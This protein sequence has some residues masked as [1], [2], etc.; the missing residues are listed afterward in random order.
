MADNCI[1]C[2]IVK[3][4]IPAKIEFEDNKILAFND[5]NPKAPVH[6][7]I[8]PKTHLESLSVMVEKEID[9]ASKLVLTAKKIAKNKKI[10]DFRLVFNAGQDAGMEIDH[11]HLH[12]LGGTKLGPMA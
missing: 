9:I 12:L 11:L 1:F 5:I 3:K 10:S 4:E 2:K 6:I 8:I 7:L